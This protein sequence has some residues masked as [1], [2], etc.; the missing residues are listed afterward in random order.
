MRHYALLYNRWGKSATGEFY[1]YYEE[2]T[3]MSSGNYVK[4]EDRRDQNPAGEYGQYQH[5]VE[6]DTFRAAA[7]GTPQTPVVASVDLAAVAQ[8]L[9]ADIDSLGNLADVRRGVVM[10]YE[11]LVAAGRGGVG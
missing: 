3:H 10:L 11:K 2:E 1:K 8:Q 6:S 5:A 9:L 4:P 7:A